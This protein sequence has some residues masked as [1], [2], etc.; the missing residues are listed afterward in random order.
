MARLEVEVEGHHIGCM[1]STADK[2]VVGM[3]PAGTEPAGM[4]LA[5]MVTVGTRLAEVKA[6]PRRHGKLRSVSRRFGF[7]L[8]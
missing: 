3:E 4:E 6:G 5:G 8:I 2:V 7:P 1:V